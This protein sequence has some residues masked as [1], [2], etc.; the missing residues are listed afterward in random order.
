MAGIDA[1]KYPNHYFKKSVLG[2]DAKK[3]RAWLAEAVEKKWIEYI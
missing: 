1:F 2:H 3:E